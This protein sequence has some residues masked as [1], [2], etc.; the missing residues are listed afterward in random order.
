MSMVISSC[1]LKSQSQKYPS[2][3]TERERQ[4]LVKQPLSNILGETAVT[5]QGHCAY[6]SKLKNETNRNKFPVLWYPVPL[7]FSSEP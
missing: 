5:H 1:W 7:V 6:I 2:P 3:I 4:R